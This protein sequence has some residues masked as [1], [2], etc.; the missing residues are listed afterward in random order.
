MTDPIANP[1]LS[2]ANLRVAFGARTEAV[3]GLSLAVGRGKTH[4]LVG[5]SGCGKS[6]SALSL[7]NLLPRGA[8]RTA[9]HIR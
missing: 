1:V 8:T 6:I 2:I 4:C 3:R 7:M 9:D 5:E